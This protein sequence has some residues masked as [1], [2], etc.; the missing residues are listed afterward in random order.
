MPVFSLQAKSRPAS[1]R[2]IVRAELAPVRA[3]RLFQPHRLDGIVTGIHHPQPGTR[4]H[5]I[6]IDANREFGG[7]VKLPAE[8]PDVG[9]PGCPNGGIA[10]V[11]GPA[12]AEREGLIGEVT[13]RYRGKQLPGPR[14]HHT[15]NGIRG[16]HVQQGGGS[17][18]RDTAADVILV[19][20]G[21]GGAADEQ[22]FLGR[23]PGD[24]D[25]RL[26]GAA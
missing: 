13:A 24:G 25:V 15:V 16:G 12:R 20:L 14:A 5:E 23:Q 11:N 7:D 8:F 21:L 1:H 22:E 9:N 26:I 2:V 19:V 18:G 17:A 3:I 10:D 6:L 4:G